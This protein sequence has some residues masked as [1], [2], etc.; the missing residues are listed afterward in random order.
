M[1]TSS[2]VLGSTDWIRKTLSAAMADDAMRVKAAA[3]A[4]IVFSLIMFT[5]LQLK[6]FFMYASRG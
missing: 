5:L 3:L 1:T 2:A 4:A 6:A